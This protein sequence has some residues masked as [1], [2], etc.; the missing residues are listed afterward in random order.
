MTFARSYL[1]VPADRL[2]RLPKALAS[3]ADMIV[4]DLEDAVPAEGK[5]AARKALAAASFALDRVMVRING[6]NTE[7]CAGDVAA[8][9]S[10]GVRAVMLPKAENAA[11]IAELS[12]QLGQTVAITAL[13]ESAASVWDV[14][15]VARA[16]GV[17]R[18]AFGSLDF[19]VD[20]GVFGDGDELLYA[21]SRLVLASRV[22]GLPSPIDG[23][24]V[25]VGNTDHVE[26]DAQ[27]ARRMGF[28]A[29]LCIHP[30]Q[31]DPVNRG[32]SPTEAEVVWARSVLAAVANAGAAAM[33]VDGQMV[34]R[35]VDQVSIGMPVR[36]VLRDVDVRDGVS[37]VGY[38]FVS[39]SHT[40]EEMQ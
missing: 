14:L 20:A 29:K 33:K 15:E 38:A 12:G 6:T 28:G 32:L 19:K 8:V 7:W 17:A 23:V 39:D 10:L 1:F 4:L 30:S 9:R 3:G 21:R 13:V 35:P 24:T 11:Q 26:E 5:E 2:E 25:S 37:I 27:A 40:H 16:P 36:L 18:L 22:A 31:V 34:E